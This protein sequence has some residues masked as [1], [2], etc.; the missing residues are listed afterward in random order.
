MEQD[1]KDENNFK[2]LQMQLLRDYERKYE[3]LSD[4]FKE[5]DLSEISK[6]A[7]NFLGP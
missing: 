7:S 4:T 3:L 1:L 5:K 6:T 2:N